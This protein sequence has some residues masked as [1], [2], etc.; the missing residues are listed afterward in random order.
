[1]NISALINP[2]DNAFYGLTIEKSGKKEYIPCSMAEVESV[3]REYL[4]D[5]KNQDR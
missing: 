3:L 4:N 1:M 5:Q 2:V